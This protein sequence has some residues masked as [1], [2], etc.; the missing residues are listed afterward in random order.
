MCVL[1]KT[2]A[3]HEVLEGSNCQ[4]SIDL[5]F[6]VDVSPGIPEEPYE[7][8]QVGGQQKGKHQTKALLSRNNS[9]EKMDE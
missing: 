9:T 5:G 1:R 6:Q 2:H 8:Q 3:E 7:L 4:I